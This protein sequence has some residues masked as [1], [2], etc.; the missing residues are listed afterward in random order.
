MSISLIKLFWDCALEL[1]IYRANNSS[2]KLLSNLNTLFGRFEKRLKASSEIE[3][4]LFV[5]ENRHELTHMKALLLEK[6]ALSS[7]HDK[8]FKN[9][10]KFNET[11]EYV[12]IPNIF[13]EFVKGIT[14]FKYQES[15]A[16]PIYHRLYSCGEKGSSFYDTLHKC[17]DGMDSIHRN[18]VEKRIYNC[19]IE[20]LIY[21]DI[22]LH[23]Q[24]GDEEHTQDVTHLE[25]LEKT[26]LDFETCFPKIKI[27]I[28]ISYKGIYP[29]SLKLMKFVNNKVRYKEIFVKELSNEKGEL[30]TNIIKCILHKSSG[31]YLTFRTYEITKP[32]KKLEKEND[33]YVDIIIPK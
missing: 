25:R 18:E 9:L 32:Y 4:E 11:K 23:I 2:P 22:Y 21:N 33:T 15:D 27:E 10:L 16:N 19:Y 13:R 12:N 7:F 5:E 3:I 26:R 8:I 24:R 29:E 20:R 14:Y 1:R 28:E 6:T 17:V 30:Y 31:I